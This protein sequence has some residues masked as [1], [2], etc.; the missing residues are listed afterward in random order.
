VLR[1]FV[2]AVV[3][4]SAYVTDREH[5]AAYMQARDEFVGAADSDEDGDEAAVGL[6]ASTL[7]VVSGFSKPGDDAF[8]TALTIS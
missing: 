4:I 5:C 3:K 2:R 7:I 1:R 8:L 6:P